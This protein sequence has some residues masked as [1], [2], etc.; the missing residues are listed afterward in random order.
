MDETDRALLRVMQDGIPLLREPFTEVARK[1][2]I[3]QDEVMARLKRLMRERVVRRFGVSVDHLRVGVVANALVAWKVPQNRVEEVGRAMS[4]HG[5][6]T[7]C[8]ERQTVPGRW[9]YNLFIVVH[10]YDRESVRR[11]VKKLS[12][13]VGLEEYLTLFSVKQLKRASAS[14]NQGRP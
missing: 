6:V 14:L 8:Y 1:T 11:F 5:E 12:R 10:G 7:H 3:D 4:A 9:E 2:G 13:A